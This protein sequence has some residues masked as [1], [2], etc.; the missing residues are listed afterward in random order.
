MRKIDCLALHHSASET[1]TVESITAEHK[2]RGFATIGYHT[3]CLKDG[4]LHPG[5][6]EAQIGASVYGAN[7]GKLAICLIGD[8]TRH[9]PTPAQWDGLGHWLITKIL[10]YNLRSDQVRGHR[11]V[12]VKNHGTLCPGRIPMK[13]I[14][15]WCHV[16]IPRAKAGNPVGSLADYMTKKQ[17]GLS[18][19]VC[20]GRRVT[21]RCG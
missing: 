4:S 9:D 1:G 21:A 11:E 14:R 3:L 16:N 15:A 18:E 2:Q 19:S 7:D 17:G 12:S 5:R 6:P 13:R 8:F 20:L 10:E